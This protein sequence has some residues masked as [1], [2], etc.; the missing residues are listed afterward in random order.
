MIYRWDTDGRPFQFDRPGEHGLG[1]KS[2]GEGILTAAEA[3]EAVVDSIR[4]AILAH[5]DPTEAM[6]R[7]IEAGPSPR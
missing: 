1:T 5:Y 4:D 2:Y 3:R 6:G 7:A